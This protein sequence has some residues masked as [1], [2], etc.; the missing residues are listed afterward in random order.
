MNAES[1]ILFFV[2]A[3]VLVGGGIVFASLVAPRS[4][5]FQ[6]F[7]PYECGMKRFFFFPGGWL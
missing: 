5:N 3:L 4:S 6:K 2:I 1:L 7:E